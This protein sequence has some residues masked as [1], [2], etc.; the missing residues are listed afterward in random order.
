MDSYSFKSLDLVAYILHII[1]DN[2][3]FFL[4]FFN[5]TLFL[6]FG[7]NL[8]IRFSFLMVKQCITIIVRSQVIFKKDAANSILGYPNQLWA[9]I[10]VLSRNIGLQVFLTGPYKP[11]GWEGEAAAPPDFSW[12]WPFTIDG[13]S[14][15]KQGAKKH[16]P[17]Q[18]PRK[19]LVYL[20]LSM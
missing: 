11:G 3:T 17:D 2:N 4:V 20:L 6:L 18:I 16:T 7:Y 8:S 14:Y 9:L 13:D 1:F 19:L 15:K 12:S 5:C 10:S